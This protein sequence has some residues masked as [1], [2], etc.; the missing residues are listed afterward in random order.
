MTALFLHCFNLS[1][2]AGWMV[3]VVLLLRFCL[4][5]APRWI[6]CVLWGLVALRLV[7]PFTIESSVSIIP[8][9]EIVVSTDDSH[10]TAVVNSGMSAID[11]TVNNWLQEPIHQTVEW[12]KSPI[13][14]TVAEP[15]TP[16]G[17]VSDEVQA[18]VDTTKPEAEQKP[19]DTATESGTESETN[20]SSGS[21]MEH[22][23]RFAAPLWL[24]GIGL[25]LLYEAF[26]FLRVRTRVWDAVRLDNNVWQSEQVASPFIFGLIR[27]RIFVPYRLDDAVMEQVLSHE[28]A[29]LRRLDHWTKPFAFTLLAVYWYNPLLWV[30]YILL[31]RDIEVAC[32]QRVIKG[33]DESGRRQYAAALLACGVERRSI[34]ACPLAFGEVSIKHRIKSV[35]H[36]RKP[37][38]FVIIVSLLVC[39]LAA[40][41]L[42]TVPL[43]RAEE[44]LG[45]VLPSESDS[46]TT[47]TTATKDGGIHSGA[48]STSDSV[49]STAQ[50][51]IGPTNSQQVNGS[52]HAHSFGSWQIATSPECAT[53]GRKVRRCSCGYTE[54]AS[55]A[56]VGHTYISHV[57]VTCGAFDEAN[58]I[59]DYTG[60]PNRIGNEAGYSSLATQGDWLYFVIDSC[61]IMKMRTD[62]TGALTVWVGDTSGSI[63][64]L[65][66]V[67]D[68]IYFYMME[69]D[70]ADSYVA[71]VRTDGSGFVVL[72]DSINIREMLI[73]DD[74]LF[75]TVM[76]S[77]YS[78]WATACCP[79]YRMP[80]NSGITRGGGNAI[81]MIHEG[82][83]NCLSSDGGY[84]Y[85]RY[86]RSSGESSLRRIDLSTMG[87]ST[88]VSSFQATCYAIE[89]GCLYFPAPIA[90]TEEYA[91]QSV[92]VNGGAV[93][94]HGLTTGYGNWLC[95]IDEYIYYRDE[96]GV[97]AFDLST[98]QS[99]VIYE[100]GN[101][102]V[103][104]ANGSD[105]I[106]VRYY[107]E[108]VMATIVKIYNPYTFTWSEG[109]IT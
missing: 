4:K 108:S 34:A 89:N 39:A 84:L 95:A 45:T 58:F 97:V 90:E 93:T 64:N 87:A 104:C 35:L 2:T 18:P 79:L 41:C 56:A 91:I 7:V 99:R 19:M 59:S 32:D 26:S 75:F 24:V 12:Q 40:V 42:L 5:K 76:E 28:H 65:N 80:I 101:L 33:L 3:L 50:T 11:Q 48:T 44:V 83:V 47:T 86:I 52:H 46:V 31:C 20:A 25:M 17:D 13:Q 88:L 43:S 103:V 51:T 98:S 23:L 94:D 77:D 14:S 62:G 73:V 78:E 9:A 105:R 37:I 63:L 109:S 27:P 53:E 21:R 96:R 72:L 67:G 85:F 6:T 70:L 60:Q 92:A 61:R 55:I 22:I 1:V 29:H 30:A 106:V 66:V 82:Y 107:S 69:I 49:P 8:T 68:W 81:Q 10:S 71:R 102:A 36:Y 15:D 38:L 16:T 100:I 74:T 57:C 54:S